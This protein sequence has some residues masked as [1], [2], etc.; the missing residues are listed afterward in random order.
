MDYQ[1][2][3]NGEFIYDKET[4]F[5]LCREPKTDQSYD[6]WHNGKN[7]EICQAMNSNTALVEALEK[8]LSLDTNNNDSNGRIIIRLPKETVS[9]ARAALQAAGIK[10]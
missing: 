4:G 3:T 9:N 8:I 7:L 2:S 10:S 6:I 1:V 5:V